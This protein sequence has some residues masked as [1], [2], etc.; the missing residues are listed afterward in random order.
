MADKELS[1]LTSASA[2]DGTELALVVQGGNS[3]QTT[4]TKQV[5]EVTHSATG[6]TTPVDNDE[7]PLVDSAASNVLKKLLW[8]NLKATL[9]TYFDTLYAATGSGVSDGDKG[10]LTVSSSGSVWTI[11]NDVVTNAKS[12]NM[13]QSTIK[14]RAAGAGTGD[15]TD[16]TASQATA[17]LDAMVGDSGSGG[18]K[19]LVPAPAGGDAAAVKFLKADGTWAVPAG[20]GGFT[21]ASTTEVLTGTD[22]SKG[23]T[24]DALAALW[25]KG[26]DVASATT[27]SLGEGGLFH[28]TGTTAITDIDFATAKDGRHAILIFDGILTLTHNATT[29]KLPGNANITTAAG[30]RAIIVQDSGDNIICVDY[31]RADGTAV[32]KATAAEIWTATANKPLTADNVFTAADPVTL[33]DA[34]TIAVDMSTFLNAKVTLGGNRTLGA[35]SNPKNGQAGCIEIVQDGTGSRT[36]TFHADWKFASAI[37]PTLSTAAGTRDLLFYQVLS[38]GKTFASLING[39][40]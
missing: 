34:A 16:L 35:P 27:V 40:A 10:D 11:D 14:G 15:P 36:L 24:P 22:T 8:S 4:T 5:S 3:R 18:T 38:T 9:K 7:L 1:S 20:T 2:L 30:D 33:T 21:A 29:L 17:I 37:A 32:N 39:V 23:V 26:A 28:I 25:E 19:G 12:A 13:A 31:R 6:K